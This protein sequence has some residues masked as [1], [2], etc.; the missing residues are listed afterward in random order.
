MSVDIRQQEPPAAEAPEPMPQSPTEGD[1]PESGAGGGG[2]DRPPRR[3]RWRISLGIQSKLLLMLCAT[4]IL[5]SVVVGYVG[6]RSGTDSLRNAAYQRLATLRNA[7]AS[8]ITRFFTTLRQDMGVYT[9]GATVVQA[10]NEF[11]PEFQ[12]LQKATVTP[13]Q[14]AAVGAY[15]EKVFVPSLNTDLGT[16]N[17]AASFLP[18]SAA[19]RYLQAHYT[20]PFASFDDAIKLDDA[21]DGSAWSATHARYQP[22]FRQLVT[23]FSYDDAMLIDLSGNVVYSAYAGVDLG[24]NLTT[25]PYRSSN[26]ATAYTQAIGSNDVDYVGLTDLARYQPSAGVPTGWAVSPVGT[27]GHIVGVLALQLPIATINQIMTGSNGWEAD[28]LGATGETFLAGP[29]R[30]MRS[31][32]RLVIQDPEKYKTQAI[33][34]GLDVADATKA[35]RVKGTILIQTLPSN[36]VTAALQGKTGTSVENDYLGQQALIAYAPLNIPG[37]QWAIIA[38]VNTAEIFAPVDTLTR[39]VVLATLAIIFIVCLASLLLAQ[40]FTRP[41]RHLVGG[42]REVS[43]GRLGAQVDV[44]G[45]GEFGELGVAFNEMSRSLQTK[46]ELLDEQLAENERLLLTI[47]PEAVAQRYREGQ[48]TIA[49]DHQD[50][51]VVFAEL[52][53]FEDFTRD[54][55]S[56]EALALLNGLVLTFD[57]AAARLGVEKVRTMRNGYLASCGLHVPRIDH[58]RRVVDFAREMEQIVSRFN[59]Q[60]SASLKVRAGIDTGTVSSGLVGRSNLVY[61]LWGD[62]VNL[63]YRARDVVGTPGIFVTDDVFRRLG[64]TYRFTPA[65]TVDTTNGSAPVWYLQE[66][67]S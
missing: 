21:G 12:Q 22:Y 18:T 54:A 67:R 32:S 20:A 64:D 66:D 47:M 7:R 51:T 17:T 36:A 58:A 6:Y 46:Q 39:N 11:V 4:T 44:R 14:N 31:T 62:A 48:E 10:M 23:G 29:D 34:A 61:D 43:A 13:A 49:D 65:G 24:T 35:A 37:L 25:G 33:T 45:G 16:T 63:A 9:R 5:S 2:G 27:P 38:K 26:L 55:T 52:V 57:E 3:R 60:H 30:Q 8:D 28:G 40:V 56:L 1:P 53:G 50:V 42:V 15:Y 41:V 59:A 19:Q